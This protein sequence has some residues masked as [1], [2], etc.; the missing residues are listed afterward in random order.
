M[1]YPE[2]PQGDSLPRPPAPP[3]P[4]DRQPYGLQPSG[5][6]QPYGQQPY[7][8]QSPLQPPQNPYGQNPYAPGAYAAAP[9]NSVLA[10]WAMIL[11][12]ASFVPLWIAWIPVIGWFTPLFP[13]AAVILGHMALRQVN[14]DGLGGRGMAITGLVLGYIFIALD[15]I[16]L[17]IGLA[18]G[19]FV[20][21]T[22]GTAGL[23]GS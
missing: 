14:R 11:G 5:Q 22:V 7:G 3:Q 12:I 15:I 21:G 8:Q 13:L 9:R 16:I 2:N 4:S 17:L 10:I 23:Y 1:S 19:A 20:V 6:P 18:I